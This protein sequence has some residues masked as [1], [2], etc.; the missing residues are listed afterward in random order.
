MKL[1]NLLIILFCITSC[2]TESALKLKGICENT[3]KELIFTGVTTGTSTYKKNTI[4]ISK[5]VSLHCDKKKMLC[6]GSM[7]GQ[8][9][10]KPLQNL[11]YISDRKIRH[12]VMAFE[13]TGGI[14]SKLI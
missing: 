11:M 9:G 8:D 12:G 1:L 2:S 7:A 3:E 5:Y 10:M 13:I 14:F 4:K 6:K